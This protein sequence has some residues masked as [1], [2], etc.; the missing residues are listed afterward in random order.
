M[1]LLTQIL[2]IS[3]KIIKCLSNYGENYKECRRN[4]TKILSGFRIFLRY[5]ILEGFEKFLRKFKEFSNENIVFHSRISISGIDIKCKR[6]KRNPCNCAHP[7]APH[8][9]LGGTCPQAFIHTA[10]LGLVSPGS[11]SRAPCT[12]REKCELEASAELI[13]ISRKYCMPHLHTLLY[14]FQFYS[15][16]I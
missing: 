2:K 8:L 7:C 11:G 1:K 15:I 14:S 12:V 9:G 6:N 13:Q 3:S 4:L 5:S 16:R 10:R